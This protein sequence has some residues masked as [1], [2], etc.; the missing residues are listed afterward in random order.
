M[1]QF[2]DEIGILFQAGF[3]CSKAKSAVFFNI[4]FGKLA[5]LSFLVKE[6]GEKMDRFRESHVVLGMYLPFFFNK[7]HKLHQ[8]ERT[9]SAQINEPLF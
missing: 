4:D 3:G 6:E 2:P 9:A 1:P 8:R 5:A 7:L